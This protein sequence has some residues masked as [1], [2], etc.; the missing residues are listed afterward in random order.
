MNLPTLSIL[1]PGVPTRLIPGSSLV[2]ELYRQVAELSADK[3]VEIIWLV[4]NFQRTIG[5]KRQALV[6]SKRS[7]P[8][9]Y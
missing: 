8:C 3:Q 9:V 7:I 4:D 1:I 5:G 2:V 6:T